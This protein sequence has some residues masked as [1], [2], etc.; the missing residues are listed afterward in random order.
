MIVESRGH[1]DTMEGTHGVCYRCGRIS[2]PDARFCPH[3]GTP[4]FADGE[5]LPD[6]SSSRLESPASGW[7]AGPTKVAK[8]RRPI[9]LAAVGLAIVVALGVGIYWIVIGVHEGQASLHPVLVGEK[10]G[11]IDTSG[12]IVI[13]PQFQHAGPFSEGLARVRVKVSGGEKAGFIDSSGK[14]VIGPQFDRTWRFSQGLAW[15][16][17]NGKAGYVDTRGR[18]TIAPQFDWAG[19]FSRVWR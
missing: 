14:I 8:S 15:F 11:F 10:V 9:F 4:I 6:S 19:D 18:I 16:V 3:C 13:E 2:E 12:R 1:M 7:S 5:A 17:L